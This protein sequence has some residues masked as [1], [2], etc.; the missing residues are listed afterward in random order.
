[1]NVVLNTLFFTYL[2]IEWNS[3]TNCTLFADLEKFFDIETN[4][5]VVT[6]I[7]DKSLASTE[8]SNNFG[9]LILEVSFLDCQIMKYSFKHTHTST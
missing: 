3:Y 2:C 5:E 4:E 7:P 9:V 1:M 6:L 8:F